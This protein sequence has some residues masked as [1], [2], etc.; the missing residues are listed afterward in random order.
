MAA[1]AQVSNEDIRALGL[2]PAELLGAMARAVECLQR[3]DAGF[4]FK[5]AMHPRAGGE[6][7]AMPATL[8]EL[9]VVKWL[10]VAAKPAPGAPLIQAQL[11]ATHIPSGRVLAL[12]DAEW[13]TAVR[14]AAISALA[15]R[16][17]RAPGT[18]SLAV[19]GC[20]LQARTHLG[21][22]QDAFALRQ[23]LAHS[24]RRSTAAAFAAEARA[25]GVTAQVLD[26]AAQ[27]L[28]AGGTVLI[29]SPANTSTPGCLDSG[30]VPPDTLV[31]AL[32][33]GVAL[34]PDSLT[35][36]DRYV[37]DH[38]GQTMAL[39]DA[40]TMPRLPRIDQDL[41]TLTPMRP[42]ERVLFVPPGMAL[43]DA[44]VAELV[45]HRLGLWPD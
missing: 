20:G 36:F 33:L 29:A 17:L 32:D 9:A 3:G 22:W 18:E 37:V 11:L 24:R 2:T 6:F 14:T 31:V 19:I 41:T 7:Y 28:S 23:V 8:G 45:L 44:A 42:G 34:K 10:N 12:I 40:G 26:T 39:M 5:Q 16:V 38:R 35:H 4:I 27:A 43:A 1:V 15:A 25:C 30:D 13:I 21:A